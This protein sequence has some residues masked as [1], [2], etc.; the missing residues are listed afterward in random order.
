MR[1]FTST[2]TDHRRVMDIFGGGMDRIAGT[3]DQ[4]DENQLREFPRCLNIRHRLG[5]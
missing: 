3:R 5:R 1:P 4:D 2:S